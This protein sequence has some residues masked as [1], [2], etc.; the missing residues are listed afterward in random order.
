MKPA[1][2]VINIFSF[3]S[4]FQINAIPQINSYLLFFIKQRRHPK[5]NQIPNPFLYT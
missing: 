1:P 5:I 2:P 3:I 4:N